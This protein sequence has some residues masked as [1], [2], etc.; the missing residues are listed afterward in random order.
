MLVL[1]S[2]RMILSMGIFTLLPLNMITIHFGVS[3][4]SHSS[5]LHPTASNPYFPSPPFY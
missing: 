5:L 3:P 1:M 2:R 4:L